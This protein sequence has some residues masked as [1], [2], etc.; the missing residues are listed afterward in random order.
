M[1]IRRQILS[2]AVGLSLSGVASAVEWTDGLN[3]IELNNF[4]NIYRTTDACAAVAGSCLAVDT[5]NDPDGYQVVAPVGDDLADFPD[6][7]LQVGDIFVGIMQ[8]R[9]IADAGTAAVWNKD[10]GTDEFS[11]YFVQEVTSIT[12]DETGTTDHVQLGVASDDPFDVLDVTAGEMF[13]F[14]VDQGGDTFL[15]AGTTGSTIDAAT[16]GDFW[17]AFGLS[18][19]LAL[20]GSD[21]DVDPALTDG[22]LYSHIDLG[23]DLSNFGDQEGFTALNLVTMGTAY[24]AGFLAGINDF[25]ENEQS[26]PAFS[27][28]TGTCTPLSPA[29]VTCNQIVGNFE[30]SSNDN[31]SGFGGTSPWVF[32]SN[33]P[34]KIY[35]VPEPASLAIFGM[36]L[37]GIAGLRRR[38]TKA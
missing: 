1:N 31:Y 30:L 32:A 10:G 24:N 34:L 11:G 38:K 20:S 9:E 21:A 8:V 37:M 19:A 33:D 26:G 16:D 3:N 25:D 22:Y 5:V 27:P 17:G 6:G 18:A 15:N 28:V 36:G 14:W 2:V 23:N 35:T 4:E 12:F 7:N 13:A 29:P